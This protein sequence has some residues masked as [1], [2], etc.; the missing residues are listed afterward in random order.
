MTSFKTANQLLR[1]G[2]LDDAV[3][4]YRE[5]IAVNPGFSLAH[6]N[7]G[8]ALVKAGRFDEAEAAF[9]RAVELNPQAVWS[10]FQLGELLRGR[11]RFEE[12]V[13]FL[14][15]AVELKSE[16]AE[17]NL[18]LGAALVKLGS[19]LEEGEACLRRA[20]ELNPFLA[21]GFYFL[22]AAADRR[23][24][25]SEAVEFYSRGLELNPS[26]VECGLGLGE[27]LG[28][29]GR[30]SEAVER[31]GRME[32][33]SGP[34]G[35]VCFG[36][37]QAL[38]QLGRWEEGVVEYRRAV[39]L[40]FAEAEVRHHLGY[41]LGQLGRWEEGVVEYRLVV[42]V[43]PKS[44]TVRH[45]L[46]YGLMQLGRWGEAAVELRRAVELY[47]GSAV[48]WQ[49]L[50]DVLR[51]LGERE[52]AEE[53]YR[54]GGFHRTNLN[55]KP[56][57]SA[58]VLTSALTNKKNISTVVITP[59]NP[60]NKFN[61][62]SQRANRLAKSL[63]DRG[64]KVHIIYTCQDSTP[65]NPEVAQKNLIEH[66][67]SASVY[68][69]KFLVRNQG[70][71]N[72]IDEFFPEDVSESIISEIEQL[73][74]SSV[75]VTFVF[76]S[77]FLELLPNHI[78]KIIDTQDK[79]SREHIYQQASLPV[80][81]F[82]TTE[83]EELNAVKR[84]NLI[85]AI[86]HKEAKY[87][88]KAGVQ[89][90]TIGHSVDKNYLSTPFKNPKKI[91]F[92][93]SSHLFNVRSIENTLRCKA[94]P[95]LAKSFEFVFAGTICR[96][97]VIASRND[98]AILGT[99]DDVDEFYKAI[100]V[101]IL[102][103]LFGTGLKIKTIEALSYGLPVFGTKTAFDGIE[104]DC[105]YHN[106]VS[107]E[108]LLEELGTELSDNPGLFLKL[109]NFSKA[110]HLEYS[111]SSVA[112]GVSTLVDLIPK[113]ESF[114]TSTQLLKLNH[115]VNFTEASKYSDLYVTQ[116]ITAY[117]IKRANEY[118]EKDGS[119]LVSNLV[120]V[121]KNE[122][123]DFDVCGSKTHI[124]HRTLS[125]VASLDVVRPLP[126]L[127]DL[128]NP[129][130]D[131]E[132]E[133]FVI[134]SNA[135]IGL[136]PHFYATV[137]KFLRQGYD[138]LIINRRTISK[139][140]SEV[141]DYDELIS[142]YGKDHPGYDCFVFKVKHLKKF[143]L[144][145][146]A[147]G[148]HL[149]G[150]ALLWNILSWAKN[151]KILR[152]CHL[153]FHIGDDNSGKDEK[154]NSLVVHNY[155]ESINIL[156]KLDSNRFQKALQDHAPD[157]FKMLYVP[158]ICRENLP[159]KQA[160]IFVH[161]MFRTGS[162]Y[163][164]KKLKNSPQ[165]KCYYEPLHEILSRL[166]SA[167]D[168]SKFD[169]LTN[170]YHQRLNSSESFWSV[171]KGILGSSGVRLYKTK[172]AYHQ[173]ADNS[174]ENNE[175]LSNYIDSL[176]KNCGKLRPILQF[177]RTGLRQKW[178]KERYPD[179]ISIYLVR[180]PRHQFASYYQTY[181]DSGGRGFLRTELMIAS[182]SLNCEYF[183]GIKVYV[184]SLEEPDKNLNPFQL[185][186]FFD[187]VIKKFNLEQLYL[188]FL[189]HWINSLLEAC[190][191]SDM[192]IDSSELSNNLIYQHEAALYFLKNYI[193]LDLTDCSVPARNLPL[194]EKR[195]DNIEK[196]VFSHFSG[197]IKKLVSPLSQRSCSKFIL[198][199]L[200]Y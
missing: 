194:S 67:G 126:L 185:F 115:V 83:E 169:N 86:Q 28:K 143:V 178:F 200:E 106:Y 104:S 97:Q 75:I 21:E 8:E 63:I 43:N 150:R 73:E 193:Y 188:I 23:G 12:A 57:R 156:R 190:R 192:I 159:G 117:S 1:E 91:G 136:T 65:T 158:N 81:F 141:D 69:S 184:P 120:A 191:Y 101:V 138:A 198:S 163:L 89:V 153:T 20:V 42:E 119:I 10:L 114:S 82:C 137:A 121:V 177:N 55:K 36:L 165:T 4:A 154:F 62:A 27:A 112:K 187:E 72:H 199:S 64:I 134:Y 77:K 3:A 34:S 99:V 38:G 26:G 18:G 176:I 175:D 84:A 68:P 123:V 31:Y 61:G 122:V 113:K 142:D 60:L 144:G 182:L 160:P 39:A 7:L 197:V 146:V 53:V 37:G 155:E 172:F 59:L 19:A 128:L 181:G 105:K 130:Y 9:R 171:Y 148:I 22:G 98:V 129:F 87:F 145:H 48:V 94:F 179:S 41:A 11:E 49:Q 103:I 6:H 56:L 25:P 139:L 92:F 51:E 124:L 102:P 80:S 14:R 107:V 32:L 2:K 147:I 161:S 189:W 111:R 85:I 162:S 44:A 166:S 140:Y 70:K 135:D 15:R 90:V 168:I 29:L 173:Y 93:G 133:E 186:S 79:L 16:V 47:P 35:P 149:I 110:L 180:N 54:K 76:L 167:E 46:G 151:P 196:I 170:S 88:S 40:G 24:Q 74:A 108:N 66:F 152:D 174:R 50:G 30:W 96:H 157:A 125:D 164:W 132:N 131:L 95:K 33:A 78:Y 118:I 13:G 100:D 71:L 116:P 17:F 127:Q 183:E 52:E 195:C 5:A 45:Q 109:S 58:S